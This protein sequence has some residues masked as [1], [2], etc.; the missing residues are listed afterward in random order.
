MKLIRSSR[1]SLKF[2]TTSK[3]QKLNRVLA[4][5]GRVCNIFIEYFWS[6]GTPSKAKLLKDVVDIP[7]D[8]WLSARLRKV[9]AREAID[10]IIAVKERWKKKPKNISIPVYRGTRMYV[11]STIAD[12]KESSE[13]KE[14][15]AWL[16]LA[17]IGEKVNMDLPIKFHKHFNKLASK[18]HHLNSYIIT[19]SYVQFAFEI[20][21]GDKKHGKQSIGIDTGINALASTSTGHQFG[22]DIKGIIERIKRCEHGSVGQKTARRTLKQRMDEVAKE[23]LQYFKEVDCVIVENLKNLGYKTKLKRRLSKNIRRSIGTWNWKYW[24]GRLEQQCEA[25]RVSFRTVSPYY[26]SQTCPCCG[27]VNS[28]NR[29]GEKFQ[30]QKCNHTDNADLNASR[31]ILNRFLTGQYGA[32]YK[33]KNEEKAI[34]VC[35]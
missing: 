8:T 23:I 30:C 28:E 12:L 16:H 5:Y 27:Y 1:C 3:K 32:C 25:N 11:S 24:L 22:L 14:F 6:T 33:P 29:S 10:M 19:D 35:L 31:N 17:S 13:A 21:T 2:A 20:E 18:G 34:S 26:T 9:A 7:H 4:E 15:D